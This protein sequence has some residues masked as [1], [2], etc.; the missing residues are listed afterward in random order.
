MK[1]SITKIVSQAKSQHKVLDALLDGTE[2][3]SWNIKEIFHS[4]KFS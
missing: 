1:V 4:G 2:R 3:Y